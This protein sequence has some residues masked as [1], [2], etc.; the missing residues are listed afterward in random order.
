MLVRALQPVQQCLAYVCG[1]EAEGMNKN[2]LATDFDD[3]LRWQQ[4]L[5]RTEAVATKRVIV[6]Q[7]A[8][9]MQSRKHSKL[10]MTSR[11]RT[12]RAQLRRLLHNDV[13]VR[14]ASVSDV[15]QGSCTISERR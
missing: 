9:E 4:P 14:Y 1:E 5:E 10:E 2:H 6:F 15:T 13:R 3:C 12:N 7:T 8:Q 11:M